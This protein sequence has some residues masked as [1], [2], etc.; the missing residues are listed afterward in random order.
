MGLE[1]FDITEEF[2]EEHAMEFFIM[3]NS[4]KKFA[5]QIDG[6]AKEFRAFMD[7]IRSGK[8]ANKKKFGEFFGYE[9]I[10]KLWNAPGSTDF[11]GFASS[12]DLKALVENLRHQPGQDKNTFGAIKKKIAYT[13]EDK[14]QLKVHLKEIE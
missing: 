13:R 1:G 12:N 7:D 4:V 9:I 6:S 14:R 11:R 3:I 5:D 8:N 2:Y 10:Q